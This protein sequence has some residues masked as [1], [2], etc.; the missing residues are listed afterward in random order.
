MSDS[1][2]GNLPVAKK[3]RLSSAKLE[4]NSFQAEVS[5]DE[6]VGDVSGHKL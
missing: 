5:G 2:E 1:E 3:T 4:E 6:N